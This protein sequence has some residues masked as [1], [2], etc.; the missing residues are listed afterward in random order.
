MTDPL[1]PARIKEAVEQSEI[2]RQPVERPD[3]PL[4]HVDEDHE[5]QGSYT[6]EVPTGIRRPHA[7]STPGAPQVTR[8]PSRSREVDR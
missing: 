5:R 4:F 3:D 2:E 6:N 7:P 1:D 8:D